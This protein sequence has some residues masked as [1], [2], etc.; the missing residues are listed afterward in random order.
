MKNFEQFVTESSLSRLWKHNI[1]H[2]CGAITA[3]R[4][5]DNCGYDEDK[6]PCEENSEP[7]LLTREQNK[8]R[9]IGLAYD[10]KQL[11]YHVTKILGKYPE[12]GS[13]K[14]EVSYFVVDHKDRGR[15]EKDLRRL[16]EKY[17]QDS[18][19]VVPKEAISNKAKA[20][21]VSTNDCC[22]NWLGKNGS[23]SQFDLAKLGHETPV[24]TSKVG[25]RPF[26]F[27]SCETTEELFGSGSNAIIAKN[28]SKQF[29]K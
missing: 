24:Y 28:F 2:D 15:L 12:G 7:V 25:G 17:K 13:T 11:D 22:N 5:Y 21:L 4:K 27:E 18:V 6:Q 14:T 26:V 9:N 29:E 1:H 3:F 20:F 8:H 16:G 19:L 23:K 10:L